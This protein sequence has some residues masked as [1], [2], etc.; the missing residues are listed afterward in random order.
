MEVYSPGYHCELPRLPYQRLGHTSEEGEL[1]GGNDS[2]TTCIT[3]SSGKWV[4]SRALAEKRH[5]HIS[6]HNKEEDK[7]I[8]MGGHHSGRTTETITEGANDDGVPG[9]PLKYNTL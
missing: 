7:T 2:P 6:W 3:F 1:C 5:L 4:T 9:F 8:L